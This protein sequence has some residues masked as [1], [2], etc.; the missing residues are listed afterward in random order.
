MTKKA[1]IRNRRE[2]LRRSID[3][4]LE[5]LRTC[6]TTKRTDGVNLWVFMSFAKLIHTAQSARVL[7]DLHRTVDV[8]LLARAV[9][10]GLIDIVFLL[11]G[12]IPRRRLTRLMTIEAAIDAYEDLSFQARLRGESVEQLVTKHPRLCWVIKNYEQ[13]RKD[14]LSQQTAQKAPITEKRW[15]FISMEEKLIP[16]KELAKATTLFEYPLR[17]LGNAAAH[18]RPAILKEF[19]RVGDDGMP[20]IQARQKTRRFL[21]KS[22]WV[23]LDIA[24]C[25]LMAVDVLVDKYYLDSAFAGRLQS[26]I[27]T[28]PSLQRIRVN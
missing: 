11:R 2:L 12:P 18:A 28:T 6:G 10:D 13:A 1:A 20:R 27:D 25:L 22:E 7:L 5:V 24:I 19:A 9:L 4:S 15:R 8:K 26:L 23:A 17:T 3:L 14:P 21:L 16:L